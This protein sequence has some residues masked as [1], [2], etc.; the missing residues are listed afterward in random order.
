MKITEFNVAGN[1]DIN[2]EDL[3][4]GI[5]FL[6]SR[7]AVL[8]L[9]QMLIDMNLKTIPNGVFVDTAY[10]DASISSEYDRKEI[11][12]F[13]EVLKEKDYKVVVVRSLNDITDDMRDLEEFIRKE[14]MI[15]IGNKDV[16]LILEK[17]EAEY[18]SEIHKSGISLLILMRPSFPIRLSDASLKSTAPLHLSTYI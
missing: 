12:W 7:R 15:Q 9:A 4:K 13:F 17:Y 5:A 10:A 18:S 16:L 2:K 1:I 14:R 8:N 6:K 3:V 11:G